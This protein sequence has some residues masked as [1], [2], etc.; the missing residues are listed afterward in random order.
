MASAR[1]RSDI[2]AV[3]DARERAIAQLSEA[4]SDDR[5]GVEDLERRLALAHRA[6]SVGEVEQIV[7]DLADDTPSTAMASSPSSQ[8]DLARRYE[9]IAAVLGGVERGGPWVVPRRLQ[10][11]AV[12]GG[13]ALDLREAVFLPGVTEIHVVAALGGV[14]VIVPQSL[15][16]DVC[17]TAILGGFAHLD[18][19]RV[20]FDPARPLLRIHG[21]ATLGGVAVEA[22]LPGE[23]EMDAHRRRLYGQPAFGTIR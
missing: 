14:Q 2:V 8:A 18:R 7:C 23:S 15:A 9:R 4:F 6:A 13:V 17:G 21:R 1:Q 11:L 10:V 19:T 22:R 16:V 5:I 20:P 3:R 12:F